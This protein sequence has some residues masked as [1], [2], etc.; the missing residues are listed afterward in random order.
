MQGSPW[1][2][3]VKGFKIPQN[4]GEGSSKVSRFV[5]LV[6]IY[7]KRLA[8]LIAARGFIVY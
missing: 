4:E 7:A 8:T 6:E 2:Q 1:I 3:P 5:T